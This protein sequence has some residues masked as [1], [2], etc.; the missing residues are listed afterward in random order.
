MQNTTIQ[1]IQKY[2]NTEI[3]KY[4]YTN[5][6]KTTRDFL[7]L[8]HNITKNTKILIQ[9]TNI[10]KTTNI[11]KKQGHKIQKNYKRIQQYKKY[12]IIQKTSQKE[13]KHYKN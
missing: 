11:T 5:I 10:T 6:R 9:K 2:K 13:T 1:K 4:K 12:K 3:Q 7:D 8:L